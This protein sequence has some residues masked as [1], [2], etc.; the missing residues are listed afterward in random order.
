MLFSFI[1]LPELVF[2]V[3]VSLEKNPEVLDP[4]E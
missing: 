3:V 2:K 4:S 1:S